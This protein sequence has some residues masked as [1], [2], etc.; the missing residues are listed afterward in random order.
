MTEYKLVVVGGESS[1]V[2]S[3]LQFY[4]EELEIRGFYLN[5]GPWR[6]AYLAFYHLGLQDIWKTRGE[7]C[8]H[9]W[10]EPVA[11]VV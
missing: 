9:F 2:R 4:V 10:G 1:T 6:D 5:W 3:P 11:C 8:A 7:L